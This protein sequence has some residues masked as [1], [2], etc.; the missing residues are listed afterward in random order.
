MDE[1]R[2]R[3]DERY[4]G[5]AEERL[6]ASP[7][8]PE[9]LALLDADAMGRLPTSGRALDIACGTGSQ[10]LW[11]AQRGLDVVALD[12]SPVAIEL[13]T[14]AAIVHDLTARIDARTHDLDAGLPDDAADV[15]IIVCQRFR[16]RG[17]YPQI[18]AALRRDGVAMITV[19]SAVGLEAAPG[20]FHA[21]AGELVDAFTTA[22]I[23]ILASSEGAG[24]ASII[25]RRNG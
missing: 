17:L 12:V 16:G 8:A 14:S 24:A 1:D 21:P 6:L 20:E 4:A 19:L 18:A 3:W 2:V 23:Q 15:S 9:A 25:I 22:G 7:Q 10:S 13:T 5:R 11:L